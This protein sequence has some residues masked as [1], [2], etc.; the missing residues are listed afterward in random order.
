MRTPFSRSADNTGRDVLLVDTA[1]RLQLSRQRRHWGG[2]TVVAVRIGAVPE[3]KPL[4]N[5]SVHR[6]DEFDFDFKRRLGRRKE[7][8]LGMAFKT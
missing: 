3:P 1:G 8:A 4:G 5:G 2:W 7:E 6:G